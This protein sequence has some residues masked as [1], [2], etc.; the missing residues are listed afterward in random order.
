MDVYLTLRQDFPEAVLP[1]PGGFG[2][3]VY[4]DPTM[5]EP[6]G[7]SPDTD[8]V[9]NSKRYFDEIDFAADNIIVDGEGLGSMNTGQFFK[10]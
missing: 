2:V 5:V 9:I 6:D 8:S 1:F 7:V 3:S 4:Y 10:H